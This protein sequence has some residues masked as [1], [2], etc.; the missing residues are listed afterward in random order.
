PEAVGALRGV[1]RKDRT[2][3][4]VAL[5]A[6][7]PL[8]V[9]GLLTPGRRVPALAGNRVLYRDGVPVAVR[10]GAEA[11]TV[12]DSGE[13]PHDLRRALIQ[14]RLPPLVLA[15]LGNAG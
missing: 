11:R 14:R 3:V 7:D 4:L 2:G 9:V 13:V 5:S 1:R 8:N 10:E 12:D 6:A 15:Y